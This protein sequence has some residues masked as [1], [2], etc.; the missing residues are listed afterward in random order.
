MI[1][2]LC[3]GCLTELPPGYPHDHV[4]FDQAL[5]KR[6]DLYKTMTVDERAELVRAGLARGMTVDQIARHFHTST[7]TIRNLA[8]GDVPVALDQ[9]IRRL[10]HRGHTDYEISLALD[11]SRSTVQRSREKQ[12]LPPMY[13]P[14]GRRRWNNPAVAA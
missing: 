4:L 10:Y 2:N 6:P 14:G 1:A 3:P 8:G 12:G 13:G 7:S 9:Q 11:V 5:T